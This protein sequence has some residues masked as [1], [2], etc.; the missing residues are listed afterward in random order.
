ML[1]WIVIRHKE[2]Q[3]HREAPIILPL[4]PAPAVDGDIVVV[5]KFRNMQLVQWFDEK[6]S[7]WTTLGTVHQLQTTPISPSSSRP[8]QARF[9]AHSSQH[10]LFLLLS[11]SFLAAFLWFLYL[12]CIKVIAGPK[13]YGQN[14]FC[15]IHIIHLIMH[16]Q[17]ATKSPLWFV[18]PRIGIGT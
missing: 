2:K 1:T 16:L 5:R 3:W 4:P 15:L 9:V 14:Y 7:R 6:T 17:I 18:L 13:Y 12:W 11:S 10:H 8:P